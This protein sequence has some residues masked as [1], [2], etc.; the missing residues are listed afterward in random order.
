MVLWL[1]KTNN[2]SWLYVAHNNGNLP[3][4]KWVSIL[5]LKQIK[6]VTARQ[7]QTQ[8]AE[9][10]EEKRNHLAR[11][12]VFRVKRTSVLT[13]NWAGNWTYRPVNRICRYISV[14]TDCNWAGPTWPLHVALNGAQTT[15]IDSHL[16]LSRHSESSISGS[17]NTA[18][19]KLTV[20]C[21]LH[22]LLAHE[23][24]YLGAHF[25]WH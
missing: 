4:H 11:Y 6:A 3:T 21:S 20:R 12:C 10:E 16:K 9:Q 13:G 2:L 22:S 23:W 25:L 8:R 18:A 19:D 5:Q 17:G 1:Q 24:F 15:A 7:L 14:C